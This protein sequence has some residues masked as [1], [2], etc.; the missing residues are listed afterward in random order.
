MF[1]DFK[2]YGKFSSS[3]IN[4]DRFGLS[5][6]CQDFLSIFRQGIHAKKE[7]LEKDVRLF[8]A[9]RDYTEEI[10]EE[11]LLYNITGTG[12]DRILPKK[13]FATEGRASPTGTELLYL[14][15]SDITA[16][17][18][19]RPW[20]GEIISIA[21]LLIVRDLNVINFS[22]G[23]GKNMLAELQL[24]EA[25]GYPKK[26][27]ETI[28]QCVWDE[29]DNAFSVPITQTDTGA[30]Y[31]PTQILAEVVKNEG[32]DGIYYKSSFGGNRGYNI[33]LFNKNDAEVRSC[34]A[35]SISN[36]NI[37]FEREGNSWFKK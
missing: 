14:A 18:E 33:A 4:E 1:K 22:Q 11:N 21:S 26:T 36:I 9:I 35:V 23:H 30:E 10:D 25:F 13:A 16:V 5:P 32:F 24:G 17:S 6:A 8:R 15:S 3:I 12:E 31:V 34:G 2:A 29:I 7:V 28:N 37:K 19:V 20:I 27:K